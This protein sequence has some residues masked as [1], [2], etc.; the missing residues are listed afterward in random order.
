MNNSLNDNENEQSS[1]PTMPYMN[2]IPANQNVES[3]V[4]LFVNKKSRRCQVQIEDNGIKIQ[5]PWSCREKTSTTNIASHLRAK[6]QI[7]E[8]KK[9]YPYTGNNIE[10]CL[11]K[12]FQKWNITEKLFGDATDNNAAMVKAIHPIASDTKTRWNST[13]FLLERLIYFRDTLP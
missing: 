6:H 12:E 1:T 7:I 8:E 10:D 2:V 4:W 3:W 11:H 5:C 13:F 9:E